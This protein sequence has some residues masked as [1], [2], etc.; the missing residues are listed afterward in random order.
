MKVQ[1]RCAGCHDSVHCFHTSGG[2]RTART[3]VNKDA[4]EAS[5][6][7][8]TGYTQ[9]DSCVTADRAEGVSQAGSLSSCRVSGT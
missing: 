9:T 4:L 5:I 6:C 2:C 1:S 8:Y 3:S 7:L